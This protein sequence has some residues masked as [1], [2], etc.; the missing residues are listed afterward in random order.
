M[1]QDSR[2]GLMDWFYKPHGSI[3]D[4]FPNLYYNYLSSQDVNFP[5]SVILSLKVEGL[6]GLQVLNTVLQ[7]TLT[8]FPTFYLC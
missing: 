2:I 4:W 7:L 3:M 1:S 5:I 6:L 8:M